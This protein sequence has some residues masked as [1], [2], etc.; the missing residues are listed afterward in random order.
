[1]KTAVEWLVEKL[2]NGHYLDEGMKQKII[3]QAKEMEKGQIMKTWYDCKLSI[4]ER[5]PTDAE[6]YYNETFKSE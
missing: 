1:M 6:Q 2:T 4:I 5:N 3:E